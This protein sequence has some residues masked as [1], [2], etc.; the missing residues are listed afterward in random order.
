MALALLGTGNIIKK[1]NDTSGVRIGNKPAF[2]A[3][4]TLGHV[5]PIPSAPDVTVV[6]DF[7]RFNYG[8]CYNN[9]TGRFTAARAGLYYFSAN[10]M[11]TASISGDHQLSLRLN[12]TRYNTSNP[13]QG[14]SGRGVAVFWTMGVIQLNAGDWVDCVYYNSNTEQRLYGEYGV[15]NHFT[16]YMVA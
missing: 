2:H 8:G 13:G 10:G 15:W 11:N 7:V 1:S 3:S 4:R 5:V 14:S 9:Q 16:G 6:F 12:G